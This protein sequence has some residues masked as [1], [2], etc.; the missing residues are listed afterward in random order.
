MEGE[1]GGRGW[2]E[3]DHKSYTCKL[4]EC[5]K[6]DIHKHILSLYIA[7]PLQTFLLYLRMSLGGV[8]LPANLVHIL[9]NGPRITTQGMKRCRHAYSSPGGQRDSMFLLCMS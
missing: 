6:T 5:M 2:R 1:D 7:I 9:W 8:Q 3:N 4:S